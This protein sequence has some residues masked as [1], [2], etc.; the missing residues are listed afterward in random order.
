MVKARPSLIDDISKIYSALVSY[1]KP[2]KSKKLTY[3]SGQATK[4]ALAGRFPFTIYEC[5]QRCVNSGITTHYHFGQV[6]IFYQISDIG[7]S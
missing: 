5:L 1:I 2:P 7:G 6:W 3:P 4:L